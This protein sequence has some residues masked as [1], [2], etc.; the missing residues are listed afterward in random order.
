MRS[1]GCFVCTS[2]QEA[3]C[4]DT[5]SSHPALAHYQEPCLANMKGRWVDSTVQYSIILCCRGGV[6]P[7][8]ACLKISGVD[9]ESIT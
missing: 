4:G 8:S 7:A 5:F 1:I 9:G 3:S 2:E 6:Y